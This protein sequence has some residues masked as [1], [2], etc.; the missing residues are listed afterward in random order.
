MGIT[1]LAVAYA[2]Q[3]DPQNSRKMVGLL[4]TLFGLGQVISPV[5]A[6]FLISGAGGYNSA[7][8]GAALIVLLGAFVLL[9]GARQSVVK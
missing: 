5:V 9:F 3:L 1:T 7:L 6:S 8:T 2:K 4:T